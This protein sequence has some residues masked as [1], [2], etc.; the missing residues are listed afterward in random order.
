[1]AAEK[2]RAAAQEALRRAVSIDA[3]FALAHFRLAIALTW[4][5]RFEEGTQAVERALA[6]RDRLPPDLRELLDAT[7]PYQLYNDSRQALPHLLKVVADDPHQRD[8]L[9]MLGESYTHSASLADSAKAAEVFDRML[10]DDPAN[11]LIYEHDLSA[12]LRRGLFDRAHELVGGW[13]Q[14]DPALAGKLAGELALWEGRYADA[15]DA[16]GD[17]LDVAVLG[18]DQSSP[19]L[20]ALLDRSVDEI[21]ASLA[22]QHGVFQVLEL[23]LAADVLAYH[24]RFDAAAELYLRAAAVEGVLSPDG[25]HSNARNG[26]RYRLA[27]LLAERGDAPGALRLAGEALALQPDNPHCLYLSTSIAARYGDLAGAREHAALLGELAGRDWGPMTA[28]YQQAA[29]AELDLAEGR[30]RE[31]RDRLQQLLRTANLMDDWYARKDSAGPLVRDALARAHRA[32]GDPDAES[33]TLDGLLDAG[34]ERLRHPVL[35]VNALHRQGCLELEAGR[36]QSGRDFLE[37][38]LLH[39]GQATA[40]DGNELAAVADARARL[41]PLTDASR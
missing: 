41:A 37:R 25:Y 30:T 19:A 10:E 27:W 3:G 36:T 26:A 35:W 11:K 4:A 6:F 32:L 16:L 31:A 28:V 22:D 34:L 21:V 1:M 2:D 8:A 9:Y 39:W 38:F 12:Y 13:R 15:A 7:R 33:E 24:G 29:T 40:L 20:A 23:D 5:G 14:D 18:A 17:R